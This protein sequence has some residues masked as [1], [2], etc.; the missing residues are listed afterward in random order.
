MELMTENGMNEERPDGLTAVGSRRVG[1]PH[2]I[3]IG[4]SDLSA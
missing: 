1:G 3:G 4:R 2:E